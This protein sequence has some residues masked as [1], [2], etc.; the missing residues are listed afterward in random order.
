MQERERGRPTR[1]C[2]PLGPGQQCDPQSR[3]TR[4]VHPSSIQEFPQA[5]GSIEAALEV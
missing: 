3:Y 5:Y 1:S 4:Q 2:I